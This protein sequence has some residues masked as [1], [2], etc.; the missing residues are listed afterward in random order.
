MI[1]RPPR[2][3]LFPYT[4]LFRSSDVTEVDPVAGKTIATI[5]VGGSKLEFA[6]SD[7]AGRVF[8]NVQEKGEIAVIDVKGQKVAATYKM[9]GCEDNSGLAYSGSKTRLLIAACGNAVAKVI[10]AD[11][12]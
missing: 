12:G 5:P 8:V 9:A 2:S 4:T 3:T 6:D 10:T 1:R 7:G 11:T